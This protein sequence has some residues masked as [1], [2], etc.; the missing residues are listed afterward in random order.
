M[1]QW[2]AR[3]EFRMLATWIRRTDR[4]KAIKQLTGGIVVRPVGRYLYVYGGAPED[5]H[6]RRLTHPA[7]T[8][9]LDPGDR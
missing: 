1:S 4:H 5:C 6:P 8:T 3:R 7:P 2:I 9:L